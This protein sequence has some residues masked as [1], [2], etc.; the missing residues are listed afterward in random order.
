MIAYFALLSFVPLTF[1]ALV[2]ARLRRPRRRVELPRH[3]SSST[4]CRRRRSATSSRSSARCRT[5]RADARDRR[6]RVPA[7]DVALALQRARVG[8]Q[9]RLRPAEPLVPA[10]EGARVD[11]A[12]VGS[13]VTL[14]V[15]LLVG[16]LGVAFLGTTRRRSSTTTCR[17]RALGRRLVARRLRLRRL[18][19]LPADERG[20]DRP[21]RA[22]GR[23]RSRRSCSRRRFQV[24][25]VY[26]RYA[27]STRC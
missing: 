13:L 8:V 12:C 11:A 24:L 27:D 18:R 20:A 2:A 22:A 16:S 10:R 4:R 14:F 15:A 1:L 3:A 23:G 9:H 7:L 25:P 5:T 6:R 21:R 26:L 17:V 19:L